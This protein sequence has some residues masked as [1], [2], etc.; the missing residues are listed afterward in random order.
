M[1]AFILHLVV[2]VYIL[3]LGVIYIGSEKNDNMFNNIFVVILCVK[4]VN[5][6]N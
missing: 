4:T 3:N 6:V 5:F 2:V 1:H